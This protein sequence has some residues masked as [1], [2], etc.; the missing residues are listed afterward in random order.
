M[1]LALW[2]MQDLGAFDSVFEVLQQCGLTLHIHAESPKATALKAEETFLPAFEQVRG[3]SSSHRTLRS[4]LH[5]RLTVS[6][7]V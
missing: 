3:H 7:S 4:C 1:Y 6:Q 2:A 5:P